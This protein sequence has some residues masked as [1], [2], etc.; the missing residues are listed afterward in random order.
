MFLKL[1]RLE[2]DLQW[3]C[4]YWVDRHL[5]N[6]PDGSGRPEKDGQARRNAHIPPDQLKVLEPSSG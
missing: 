2:L 4:K 3:C 1:L 6:R 5:A